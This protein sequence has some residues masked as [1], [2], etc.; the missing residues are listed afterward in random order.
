MYHGAFG[1]DCDFH[2]RPFCLRAR[3]QRRRTRAR[4]TGHLV[5]SKVYM[6]GNKVR[7]DP[8]ETGTPTNK[9]TVS[10]T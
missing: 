8:E 2:G 10:S 6:S 3:V 7:F 4:S 5:K 1:S 9:S